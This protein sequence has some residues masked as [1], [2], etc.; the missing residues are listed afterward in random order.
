MSELYELFL[1]LLPSGAHILDLGCGSGRDSQAF[2]ALGFQV[3]PLEPGSKL[4]E[5]AEAHLKCK[6]DRYKVQ[7]LPYQ[8]KFDG[9]W[10]C[11]TLLHL[12]F[13]E[14]ELALSKLHQAL[15]PAGVIFISL[16]KGEFEGLR[17]GRFFCDY[18]LEKFEQTNF[19]KIGFQ[20]LS[21]SESQDKRPGRE[22]ERWLNLILRKV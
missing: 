2:R 7:E 8:N 22:S 15:K 11:A 12:P 20:L 14:M 18:S 6:V 1:P 3:T 10:A 16:K 17:S 13:A 9:I 21:H 4:A 19:P 5:L